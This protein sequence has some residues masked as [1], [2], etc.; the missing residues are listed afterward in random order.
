MY[1]K[2]MIDKTKLQEENSMNESIFTTHP[3][4]AQ[5]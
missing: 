1:D 2:I 3:H 5:E 4:L